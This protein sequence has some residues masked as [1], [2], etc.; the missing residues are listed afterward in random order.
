[1]EIKRIDVTNLRQ[2]EI[3]YFFCTQSPISINGHKFNIEADEILLTC[4]DC[5][6]FQYKYTDGIY[7]KVCSSCVAC[8]LHMVKINK[9]RYFR[10][11]E[12]E[13]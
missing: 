11:V 3:D 6:M 7:Q 9:E 4:V 5:D 8:A 13:K 1:M 12:V 2:R 10:L